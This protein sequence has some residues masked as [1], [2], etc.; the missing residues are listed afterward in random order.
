MFVVLTGT[1]GMVSGVARRDRWGDRLARV[2][3][4]GAGQGA[5]VHRCRVGLRSDLGVVALPYDRSRLP[6]TP[7]FRRGSGC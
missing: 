1:T 4:S 3:G 6:G 2:S 5:A 7:A